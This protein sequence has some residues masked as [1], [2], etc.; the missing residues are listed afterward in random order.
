M[1]VRPLDLA[2]RMSGRQVSVMDD[3]R[4]PKCEVR[5]GRSHENRCGEMGKQWAFRPNERGLK[6]RF[7][8]KERTE[9]GLSHSAT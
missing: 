5:Q 4:C 7:A 9:A 3:H 2:D 6:S 8:L 1:L